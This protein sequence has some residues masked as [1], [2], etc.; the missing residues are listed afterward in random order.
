MRKNAFGVHVEAVVGD[1]DVGIDG[2]GVLKQKREVGEV[3]QYIDVVEIYVVKTQWGL[4]KAWGLVAVEL[5]ERSRNAQSADA[6]LLIQDAT[7]SN[8]TVLH[9]KTVKEQ[10]YD[11]N[12]TLEVFS[13]DDFTTFGVAKYHVTR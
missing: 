5:C 8:A 7:D 11:T 4:L 6:M 13:A 2:V 12:V 3:D 9:V 10:W 1:E